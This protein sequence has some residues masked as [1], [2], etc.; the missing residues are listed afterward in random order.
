MPKKLESITLYTFF[1]S[2]K[3]LKDVIETAHKEYILKDH[4]K[5]NLFCIHE[6]GFMWQ[7]VGIKDPR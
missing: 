6:W 1:G 4:E 5:L 7:K 3:I 2:I